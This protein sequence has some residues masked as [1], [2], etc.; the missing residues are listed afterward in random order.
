MPPTA[1]KP[2]RTLGRLLKESED[3]FCFGVFCCGSLSNGSEA[4]MAISFRAT[5]FSLV[6]KQMPGTVFIGFTLRL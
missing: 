1:V 6:L 2:A 4:N 5:P 3:G